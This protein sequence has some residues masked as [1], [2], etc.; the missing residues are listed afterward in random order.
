MITMYLAKNIPPDN[1]H[2]KSAML[3]EKNMA[4]FKEKR[5]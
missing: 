2:K 3:F 5:R 1:K 4:D